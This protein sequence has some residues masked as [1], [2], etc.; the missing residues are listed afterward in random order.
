MARRGGRGG[1]GNAGIFRPIL[2]WLR[3]SNRGGSGGGT[4]PSGHH[5]GPG[6]PGPH[7]VPRYHRQKPML[8]KYRHE[9]DPN[10]PANPFPGRS[11]RRLSPQEREAHRVFVDGSGNLRRARDG[12]LYDTQSGTSAWGGQRAIFVMDGNG[13]MY[14]SNHH[15]PGHF[16]HSS[17]A[18]GHP[19]AAAGELSVTNGRVNYATAASGHYQPGPEHMSNLA[20][21]F[22]R[23]GIRPPIWDFQGP[24]PGGRPMFA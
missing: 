19:V 5:G 18:G 1:G 7:T 9:T 24:R 20:Q 15:A 12:S 11:V 10:H 14:A 21:E 2:Q 23:N 3:R 4:R 6:T 13:N 8:D 17:L 22:S 16:H